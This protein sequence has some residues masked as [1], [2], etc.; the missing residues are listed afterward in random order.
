MASLFGSRPR[1]GAKED[2]EEE[3][4]E[5]MAAFGGLRRV[6]RAE[7]AEEAF[8]PLPYCEGSIGYPYPDTILLFFNLDYINL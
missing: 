5:S 7:E 2:E 6:R 3:L 1:F 8:S 4:L